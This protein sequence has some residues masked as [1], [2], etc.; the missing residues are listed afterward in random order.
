[1]IAGDV[2]LNDYSQIKYKTP[3][4][5]GETLS[6]ANREIRKNYRSVLNTH[7]GG[8]FT[9][10]G[11]GLKIRAGYGHYKSPFQ[12][13]SAEWD[14]KVLSIGGGIS[15]EGKYSLDVC[16]SKS[17]WEKKPS[18]WLAGTVIGEKINQNK[19]ILSF[20]YGW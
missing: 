15:F 3:P 4:I 7:V 9:V 17:S 18:E 6:G 16:Y 12:N 1:M 2:E 5:T 8:Q 19:L 14:R 10:P 20:T 13:G 11:V